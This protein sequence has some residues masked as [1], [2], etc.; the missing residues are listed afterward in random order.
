MELSSHC[1]DSLSGISSRSLLLR[2]I[3]LD[4]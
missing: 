3:T 1:L 2:N 4:G